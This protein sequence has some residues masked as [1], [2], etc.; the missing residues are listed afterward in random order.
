MMGANDKLAATLH[1]DTCTAEVLIDFD[2]IGCRL[3]PGHD[4]DHLEHGD[5]PAFRWRLA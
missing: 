3:E 2:S 1:P 5:G 4:G